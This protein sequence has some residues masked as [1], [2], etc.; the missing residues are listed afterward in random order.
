MQQATFARAGMLAAVLAT[1]GCGSRSTPTGSPE[2]T[3][4]TADVGVYTGGWHGGPLDAG[5]P[6]ADGDEGAVPGTAGALEPCAAG[7]GCGRLTTTSSY[8][9]GPQPPQ[10]LLDDLATPRPAG[11]MSL[12]VSPGGA[13]DPSQPETTRLTTDGDG[14]FSF[15]AAA[16][17]YCIVV[18]AKADFL[19]PQ[20]DPAAGEA[21]PVPSFAPGVAECMDQWARTCDGVVTVGDAPVAATEFNI[22]YGC[23]ENPCIPAVP[24]P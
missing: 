22:P 6:A 20:G 12:V 8:C 10:E 5:A 14:R 18:I 13:Y 15:A 21:I 24:Y 7:T 1:L 3:Y 4:E 2:P 9:G 11:G 19:G 17:T 23:S 16:G